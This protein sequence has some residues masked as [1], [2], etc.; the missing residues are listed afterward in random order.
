MCYK[1]V[2]RLAPHSCRSAEEMTD[3]YGNVYDRDYA[4]YSLCASLD[5]LSASVYLAPSPGRHSLMD[6]VNGLHGHL[7]SGWV[8]A[9]AASA[10]K[11]R[12]KEEPDTRI[13]IS[14][15]FFQGAVVTECLF[16]LLSL[17]SK[18]W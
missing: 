4:R 7:V 1:P 10:E 5:Q 9:M 17:H 14:L 13:F 3:C 11:T 18:G 2:I 12:E 6:L 15:T 8:K 16:P